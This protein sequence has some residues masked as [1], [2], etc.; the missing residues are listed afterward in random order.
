VSQ[1]GLPLLVAG[2][3]LPSLPGLA[4]E[5]RSYAER[6]FRY[7]DIDSLGHSDAAKALTLPAE[8]EG[9]GWSTN[10]VERVIRDTKGYPY[11]L[12]EF[13]KQ[14][15]NRATGTHITL[16]DVKAATKLAIE[17]LD[18]GFFRARIDKTTDTERDYL[19]AMAALGGP[20]PYRSG[21]VSRQ[22]GKKT[23]QT[24]PTRDS[25]IKRGLCYAPRH[26]ELS[27]TVPMFDEF[28]RRALT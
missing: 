2:A 17:D 22:L 26:G 25:L 14:A 19:R 5:A 16:D 7:V 24:G 20:G 3:G 13:G 11:F 9:A 23:T 27:F 12:Q 6:L 4:G 8:R 18:Q 21:D 1:L 15:W 28:I 10:A